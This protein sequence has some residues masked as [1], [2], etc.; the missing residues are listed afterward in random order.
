MGSERWSGRVVRP[1]RSWIQPRRVGSDAVAGR[2]GAGVN[3]H[4]REVDAVGDRFLVPADLVERAVPLRTA[5]DQRREQDEIA[6]QSQEPRVARELLLLAADALD[7]TGRHLVIREAVGD[8]VLPLADDL[9]ALADL[10][11]QERVLEH[12]APLLADQS[13]L[14]VLRCTLSPIMSHSSGPP[15]G[16]EMY[17]T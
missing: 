16:L 15:L 9:V 17:V 7:V 11:P 13:A 2:A 1:S 14:L 5:P 12:S 3:N 6:A 10:V 4:L 8:D